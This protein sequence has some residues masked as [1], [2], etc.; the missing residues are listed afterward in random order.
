MNNK[1]IIYL[2]AGAKM[3]PRLLV[4]IYTLRKHYTGPIS[5]I[6]IGEDHYS[7][8]NTICKTI[9]N[10][11]LVNI[12]DNLKF[13]HHYWFEKSRTH[14]YTPYDISIFIDSDTI[15]VNNFDELFD[16]IE[17]YDFI[18]PQF[19]N[20]LTCGRKISNRL[21]TWNH[22][23]KNLVDQTISARMPSI[24]VGVYGF[25]KTSELMHNW[26]DFTIQNQSSP[27]PEETSCHLLLQKYKGKIV[28]NKYNCSCK[29]DDPRASDVKII[30]YHGRK[31]CRFRNQE[32]IFAC[33]LWIKQWK[34]VF[35]SNLCNIQDWYARVG[36]SQLRRN[37]ESI[38]NYVK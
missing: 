30:H 15:I 1:G 19:A 11:T 28:S 12:E 25:K 26:F 17:S 8:C 3:L 23:D 7:I 20:W 34:E 32:P 5:I 29:H 37:I 13:R 14:L 36:D 16:E 35:D 10:T 31:H 4:S 33:D 22:I 38:N 2:N 9:D 21:R 27:L 6:S 18:V 24:N